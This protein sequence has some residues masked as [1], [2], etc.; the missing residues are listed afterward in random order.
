MLRSCHIGNS[1]KIRRRVVVWK[2]S[3]SFSTWFTSKLEVK[4]KLVRDSKV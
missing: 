1:T 3:K 2:I 4:D